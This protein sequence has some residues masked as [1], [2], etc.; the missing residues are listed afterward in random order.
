M[1]EITLK[2]GAVLAASIAPFSVSNKLLKT[3][4]RELKGV[5]VEL[6]NLDFS[7]LAAQDINTLKNAICQIL[8]S[9]AI[10]Q[11][12]FECLAKCTYNGTRIV[13]DTFDP[14]DARADYLPC[15]WEVIKINL[16]PFFSGL[17]LSLLTSEAPKSDD[18]K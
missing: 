12:V 7:K 16:R 13:R 11:A 6:E 14:E 3:I 2:S 18:P 15:A 17:D 9:D 8:G 5:D 10:E 1:N 4:V